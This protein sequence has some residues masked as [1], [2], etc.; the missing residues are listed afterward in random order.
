MSKSKGNVVN[1]DSIVDRFGADTLRVYE[2]FMG[3]FEQAIEWSESSLLGPRRFLE[4]VWRLKDKIDF[5]MSDTSSLIHPTVK[6]ISEDIENM[7]FNTAVSTLMIFVNQF[8]KY[9]AIPKL[10]YEILLKL[11]APFAPH[12]S[13]ELW[14]ALGHT[15]SI[16]KEPWPQYD[17]TKLVS[18][19]VTIVVQV[20]GKVRAQFSGAHDIAETEALETAKNLPEVAKWIGDKKVEKHVY[21][22]GKLVNFVVS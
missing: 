18:D 12:I 10:E 11:L 22:P 4:K 17:E 21:V 20:N 14:H 13:E 9:Q 1:P 2:M 3:P 7:R 5:P 16:H 19:T 6:K 8:D 15:D